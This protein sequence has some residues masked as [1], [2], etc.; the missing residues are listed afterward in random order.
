MHTTRATRRE[1]L[2]LAVLALPTLLLS[3]DV[4]VLYLALPRLSAD[5]G[6]DSTQ[7]LWILDIYSFML[8]GFLVTMGTLGDRIGRRRMLLIGAVAFGITSVLAAYA[9]SPGTLIAARA[10]LGIAGATLMPSTMALIRNMFRDPKQM[11]SAF[12]IWFAC[13]MGGMTLGPLVG[14]ALLSHFWWGSAFLL[15]V[16]FMALLLAVGPS[17]LP[18]YRDAAAGRL[19]LASVALSLG[20]ILPVI[21]GLKEMARDGFSGASVTFVAAGVVVGVVFVRRQRTLADP[22]LDLSLFAN[23]TFRSALG[24][25]LA[26]GVVMAGVSL[27]STLYLQTVRGLPPLQTGL[28]MV[29]QMIAMAAGMLG[30]PVLARKVRPARLMAHGLLVAAIGLLALTFVDALGIAGVVIGLTLAGLGISPTMSLT[31]NLMM[32]S[33]APEKAGSAA[34][35]SETSGEFGVA[36]GVASLG[37]LATVV[38]RSHLSLPPDVPAAADRAARQGITEAFGAARDLP[39]SL[40]ADLVDAARTAFTSAV[41][42]VAGVGVVVFVGLAVLVAVAFRNVPPTAA[43]AV[44]QDE[45][46]FVAANDSS[47]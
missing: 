47:S 42:T 1:W 17:L 22:L 24:T 28:W 14:G 29:P 4:S 15:G 23:R 2:G 7:Q 6:A 45:V 27:A 41:T 32:G 38:Y 44:S 19:D 11:A 25:G 3:L 5:L 43:A 21:Y 36:M 16:P 37:S 13:F 39:A 9:S 46:D 31:M 26:I 30:A 12:G 8:A 40:A 20:T 35:L 34:S 10:L 33:T 18:E